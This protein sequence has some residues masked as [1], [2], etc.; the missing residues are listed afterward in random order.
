MPTAW[1][2]LQELREVLTG[3]R[4]QWLVPYRPQRTHCA[5]QSIYA[6]PDRVGEVRSDR[7]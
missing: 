4:T 2:T 3:Q 1:P 7:W 5:A 6:P